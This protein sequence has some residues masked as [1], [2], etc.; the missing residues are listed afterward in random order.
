MAKTAQLHS[1]LLGCNQRR[2]F[3]RRCHSTEQ[4]QC[5][6]MPMDTLFKTPDTHR[7]GKLLRC[8]TP[9][10]NQNTRSTFE[11]SISFARHYCLTR[12]P[13]QKPSKPIRTQ[14]LSRKT[15]SF[16]RNLRPADFSTRRNSS[17]TKC[18]QLSL[19]RLITLFNLKAGA[20]P[21]GILYNS[22][23]ISG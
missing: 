15:L 5:R 3:A 22:I 13:K 8:P 12:T 17:P 19:L 20:L 16:F 18:A 6:Q 11:D 21:V 23:T 7:T 14:S 10:Q 1:K 2:T 4:S 9:L